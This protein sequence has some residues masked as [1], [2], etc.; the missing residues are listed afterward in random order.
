MPEGPLQPHLVPLRMARPRAPG[1]MRRLRDV[2]MVEPRDRDRLDV[3]GPD[4]V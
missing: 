2:D 3:C 4:G 1:I